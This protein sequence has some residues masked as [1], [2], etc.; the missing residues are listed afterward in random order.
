MH[1]TSVAVIILV[2]IAFIVGGCATTNGPQDSPAAGEQQSAPLR[3][4]ITPDSPPMIF[5]LNDTV[6]G[7][8]A[9]FARNLGKAL[10]RQVRF[11]ELGRDQ[12]FNSLMEGKVD[13]IMSGLSITE[14]RKVRI[15]FTEPYLKSGLMA[16]VRAADASKYRSLAALTGSIP[17]VGVIGGTTG[18]A[19]VRKHFSGTSRRIIPLN[20]VS[21]APFELK[22][23][24]I[25]VFIHD[26]PA[27]VWLVSE[28]EASL[29]VIPELIDEE[30]LAWAVRRDDSA[31]LAKVNAALAA[32]NKDGTRKAILSRWLPYWKNFD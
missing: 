8:E 20:R 16:A 32:W 17:A 27:V 11:V 13:I 14:A 25:D 2:L 21:D 1:K 19:Y 7:I 10:N 12:R 6:S 5:R 28:N 29:K 3:V 31:L 4:G 23:G 24:R 18:E 9:D 30:D 15:A 22:G 26:A